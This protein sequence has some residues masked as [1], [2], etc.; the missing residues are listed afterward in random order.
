[1]EDEK[2]VSLY[3][4]RDEQA[5]VETERKYGKYCL[6]IALRI[7]GDSH[8]AEECVNDTYWGAWDSIPPHRPAALATYLGKITRRLSMKV[9]RNRDA[10]KR[11]GGETALSLEELN[12]CIPD[13]SNVEDDLSFKE[14]VAILNDFLAGLPAPERR[15]FLRRYWHNCS[16]G[17]ICSQFGFSKSKTESMLHRTRKKLRRRLEKEGWFHEC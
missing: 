16:I 14:L 11:G 17:E 5:I 6:E 12:G 4:A 3:W 9:W 15:V 1:M 13:G 10:Q 7:L 2:I 8:D